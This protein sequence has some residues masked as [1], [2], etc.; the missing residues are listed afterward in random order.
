M[1]IEKSQ[2]LPRPADPSAS[3]RLDSRK[4]IAAYLKRD[5]TSGRRIGEYVPSFGLIW[6][7]AGL[8]DNDRAFAWLER[9]FEGVETE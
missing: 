8:G 2:P 4:E 9:S 6:A 1:D 5:E 3:G 7:Y